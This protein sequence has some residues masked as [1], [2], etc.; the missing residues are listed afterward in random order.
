[1]ET[2]SKNESIED[3]QITTVDDLDILEIIK[4][5]KNHKSNENASI[6]KKYVH[7]LFTPILSF[8]INYLNHNKDDEDNPDEEDMHLYI[9]KSVVN[10]IEC[11]YALLDK[12]IYD[13]FFKKK[14]GKIGKEEINFETS[15]NENYYI[16][17]AKKPIE[18]NEHNFKEIIGEALKDNVEYLLEN[19]TI[20]QVFEL[21]KKGNY[22]NV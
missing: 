20:E 1:M 22:F 4:I 5:L 17:S 18:K 2:Q 16:A 14:K 3:Y 12:K 21:K 9:G 8:I 7:S 15:D 10:D 11:V 19:D 13:L 6:E